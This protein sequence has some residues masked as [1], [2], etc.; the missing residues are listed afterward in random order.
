MNKQIIV[1]Q[2]NSQTTYMQGVRNL[3]EVSYLLLY[4][5]TQLFINSHR[6]ETVIPWERNERLQSQIQHFV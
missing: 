1:A 6:I 5:S 2:V 4:N 3:C